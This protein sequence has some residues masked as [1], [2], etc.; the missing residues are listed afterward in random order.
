MPHTPVIYV[1]QSETQTDHY[2]TLLLHSILG[3]FYLI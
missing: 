3:L 2:V 1:R